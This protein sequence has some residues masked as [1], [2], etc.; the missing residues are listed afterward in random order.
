MLQ[1][2][3]IPP[4][5]GFLGDTSKLSPM[6]KVKKTSEMYSYGDKSYLTKAQKKLEENPV[7]LLKSK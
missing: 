1:K 7:R 6:H 3:K 5:K 4:S 2:I